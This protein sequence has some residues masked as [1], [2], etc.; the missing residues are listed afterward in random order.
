[1]VN[2]LRCVERVGLSESNKRN[3][4]LNKNMLASEKKRTS[5]RTAESKQL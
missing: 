3:D 2:D 5:K 4:K 1:M